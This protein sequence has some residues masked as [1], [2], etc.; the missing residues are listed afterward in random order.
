MSNLE[1]KTIK[2][3]SRENL[4]HGRDG[5]GSPRKDDKKKD[6]QKAESEKVRFRNLKGREIGGQPF[7]DT[8]EWKVSKKHLGK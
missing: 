2:S 5:F 4:Q 3:S 7:K 8:P 1:R 6:S